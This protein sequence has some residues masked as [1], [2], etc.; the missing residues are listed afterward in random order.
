M[1]V[2]E[3]RY[4]KAYLQFRAGWIAQAPSPSQYTTP[5]KASL[6]RSWADALVDQ[7][8]SPPGP[9]LPEDRRER[10]ERHLERHPNDWQAQK[11]LGMEASSV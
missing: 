4:L 11:A 10:L 8:A 7:L 3:G 1:T 9:E 6:L 2:G 5:E